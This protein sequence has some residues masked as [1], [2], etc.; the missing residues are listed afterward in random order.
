MPRRL[1]PRSKQLDA[2]LGAQFE[3]H[4]WRRAVR[5]VC[6]A[7]HAVLCLPPL[8]LDRCQPPRRLLRVRRRQRQPT[9]ASNATRAAASSHAAAIRAT[10]A[11][12]AARAARAA[13]ATARAALSASLTTQRSTAPTAALHPTGS[14]VPASVAAVSRAAAVTPT[15]P[16]GLGTVPPTAVAA[17]AHRASATVVATSRPGAAAG[18]HA[19]AGTARRHPELRV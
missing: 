16:A 17:T 5:L 8:H 9:G 15:L 14:V 18:G 19:R 2:P 7:S 3:Q 10:A 11:A 12:V 1:R 13:P 4:V 6:W